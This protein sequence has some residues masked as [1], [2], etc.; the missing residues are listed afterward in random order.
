MGPKSNSSSHWR[1]EARRGERRHDDSPSPKRS[2]PREKNRPPEEQEA[3]SHAKFVSVLDMDPHT[4]PNLLLAQYA[5]VIG[6]DLGARVLEELVFNKRAE[7]GGPIIVWAGNNLPRQ[8]RVI[9]PPASV[10]WDHTS[11]RVL[12]LD[13]GRFGEID[14]D[15]GAD[16]RLEFLVS[17]CESQDKVPHERARINPSS[18]VP[19]CQH[20]TKR[21]PQGE[22]TAAPK[23]IVKE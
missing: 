2:F 11:Y 1:G 8:V 16:I 13:P 12:D 15:P 19:L 22:V 20:I 14:A 5:T 17:R 18:R 4:S 23:A 6:I 21:I 7:L 3:D 9:S 10:D